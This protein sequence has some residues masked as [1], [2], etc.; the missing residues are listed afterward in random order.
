MTIQKIKL[1][2]KV[3]IVVCVL[4]VFVVLGL[5]VRPNHTFEDARMGKWL[6]LSDE[7][8]NATIHRVI[9]DS[10]SD[11]NLLIQCVDKIAHLPHANDMQIQYAIVFCN[12]AIFQNKDLQK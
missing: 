5:F 6:S 2:I 11:T 8:K 3:S 1:F 10:A 4:S 12:Q 7:Q 9:K